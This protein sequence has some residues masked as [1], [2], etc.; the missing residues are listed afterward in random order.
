MSNTDKL[1]YIDGLGEITQNLNIGGNINLTETLFTKKL[2]IGTNNPQYDLDINGTLGITGTLSTPTIRPTS[3]AQ[4][5]W[6]PVIKLTEANANNIAFHIA[7]HYALDTEKHYWGLL[8]NTNSNA[9]IHVSQDGNIVIQGDLRVTNTLTVDSATTLRTLDISHTTESTSKDTGALI[10][11]GGIGIAKNLNIGGNLNINKINGYTNSNNIEIGAYIDITGQTFKADIINASQYSYNGTPMIA[12]NRQANFTALEIKNSTT[13]NT[14]CLINNSDDGT[15]QIDTIREYTTNAGVTIHN[16]IIKGASNDVNRMVIKD[17]DLSNNIYIQVPDIT[18]DIDLT[19]PNQ[20]GTLA[21]LS[22]ISVTTVAA[23]GAVMNTGNENI[24]GVKTFT[25]TIAGS[26]NGNAATATKIDSIENSNIIQTSGHQTLNSKSLDRAILTGE[27]GETHRLSIRDSNFSNYIYLHAPDLS[28]DINLTLPN[29][30]GTLALLSDISGG[31]GS[32]V[33][34]QSGSNA[35]YTSGYVGIGIT[36]P[37]VGLHIK[38]SGLTHRIRIESSNSY[39]P[40]LEF[41]NSASQMCYLY[42]GPSSAGLPHVLHISNSN[43]GNLLQLTTSYGTWCIDAGGSNDLHFRINNSSSTIRGYIDSGYHTSHM[44]NFTGQHRCV[45]NDINYYNSVNNYIG[46]IVYAT[47]DYKTYDTQNDILHS[48]NEA[49]TINDTL[50]VIELT[51]NK[52]NKAV[53]GIISD[54]EEENRHYS[55]GSFCTPISNEND[56]KRLYINSI[57]EGAIWIVNTNGNLEN[58]DYIQSSDVIGMGEKQD[59]DLLHNYTVAKITCNCNFDINS[60][61]Y[62]CVSFVDSTSGNTYLKAFV[63]CTYHCG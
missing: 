55:A 39:D 12:G 1:L 9:L 8:N 43:S 27:N 10:V 24:S 13:G 33:W 40:V 51:S 38:G 17:S 49:I 36:T 23:A 63:G 19:L 54:K 45:P 60:T 5:T 14:N 46:L 35:Y 29:Q 20:S 41:K 32:S 37:S 16:P 26:I 42:W 4:N 58:G 56:D 18:S 11:N 21:L 47:G 57:G 59:D 6:N 15:I 22:D 44:M 30:G 28:N 53:F 62:N 48:D 7:T 50:P 61:K 52:K 3:F 34:T 25:S 31:G 2:G